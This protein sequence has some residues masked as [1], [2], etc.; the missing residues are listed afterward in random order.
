MRLEPDQP[1]DDVRAGPLQLARPDDVRLFVEASL[2]LDED[3]DLLAAFGRPDERLDE[4]RVT[5]RAVQRLLDRQDVR[6]VRGL[7]DEPL[8]GRG[9]RLVRVVDQDVAGADGREH[10][11][12]L[13]VI[14]RDEPRR[15]HRCPDRDL[16]V[17]P[18]QLGDPP[19]AGEVEHPLIS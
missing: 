17:R 3:H 2:D 5:G 9:E 1:V 16:Q 7:G 13:V 14:G 11:R 10:V 6:V 19:Q 8:H 4:R 12:R 15:R 18:V